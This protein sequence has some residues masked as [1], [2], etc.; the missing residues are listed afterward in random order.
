MPPCCTTITSL[1]VAAAAELDTEV[2]L[3]SLKKAPGESA[4]GF[5]K[6]VLTEGHTVPDAFLSVAAA[7]IG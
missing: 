7:Q 4:A 2:F 1:P 5:V 6:R 3:P